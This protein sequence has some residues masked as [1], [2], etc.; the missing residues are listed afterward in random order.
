MNK[1]RILLMV[2]VLHCFVSNL[3]AQDAK[4]IYE[5]GV[6]LFSKQD[7]YPAFVSFETAADKGS[8]EA[9]SELGWCYL[10]GYGTE[11]DE[12]KSI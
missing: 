8:I 6:K 10:Y 3:S 4:E 11:K 12:K 1:L 2:A 5:Q 9:K 7:Y